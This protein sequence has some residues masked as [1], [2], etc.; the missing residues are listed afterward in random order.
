MDVVREESRPRAGAAPF[1]DRE[2]SLARFS[3]GSPPELA[4]AYH[5]R[6][7]AARSSRHFGDTPDVRPRMTIGWDPAIGG[8]AQWPAG[9]RRILSKTVAGD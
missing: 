9:A 8:A 6:R 7:L 4:D 1:D 2:S 3:Y 5:R